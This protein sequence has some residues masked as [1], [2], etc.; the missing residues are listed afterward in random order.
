[1]NPW[2][3]SHSTNN[4]HR[5][6]NI[7][8]LLLPH[9]RRACQYVQ[10]EHRPT[11]PAR[12]RDS[13]VEAWLAACRSTTT[14]GSAISMLTEIRN[15]ELPNHLRMAIANQQSI[16][17]RLNGG[18]DQSDKVI[19]EALNKISFEKTDVRLHCF[20]GRLLLSQT[21]NA[22]LRKEFSKARSILTSWEAKSSPP[23]GLELQ[24][25]RLKNTVTGRILQYEGFFQDACDCLKECLQTVPSDT[26]R[27]HIMHHLADVYCELGAPIKAERLIL[28]VVNQLR[29]QGKQ[30]SK[31]F[32]R[33]ALPLVEA[34]IEQR[35]FEAAE[36]ILTELLVVF[37]GIS[38]HDVA[39]QLD[40]VRSVLGLARINWYKPQWSEAR[41]SLDSAL[42]LTG[43]YRTFSKKNFYIGVIH[44]FLSVVQLQLAED[45]LCKQIPRHFMPGMGS[46]FLDQLRLSVESFRWPL[47]S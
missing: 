29:A 44:V 5:S 1:M 7:E 42:G 30:H 41:Q 37:D 33:L 18:H 36:N 46:Y 4:N 8:K 26:G 19:Q 47:T 14:L 25:L 20:Y 15:T 32:R 45:I 27:F 40:H 28:N 24:V 17:L 35:N 22:I 6:Q 39:D 10:K 31:P 21:E 12:T 2:P 16:S 43:K 23:S 38:G 13:L 9:L 34:Y 11:L 3:S